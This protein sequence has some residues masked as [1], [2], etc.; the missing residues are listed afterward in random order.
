MILDTA[1]HSLLGRPHVAH[2]GGV[3]SHVGEREADGVAQGH[4]HLDSDAQ[5]QSLPGKYQSTFITGFQI[6]I[7]PE[8]GIEFNI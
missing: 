2:D 6:E 7:Q 1:M 5:H 4:E 3:R 8:K